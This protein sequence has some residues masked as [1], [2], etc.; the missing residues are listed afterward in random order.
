MWHIFEDTLVLRTIDKL[1]KRQDINS[2][3]FVI[4]VLIFNFCCIG[5]PKTVRKNNWDAKQIVFK[6]NRRF[7]C[8]ILKKNQSLHI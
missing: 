8:L 3:L 4:H 1:I 6:S 5:S 7:I 2:Q